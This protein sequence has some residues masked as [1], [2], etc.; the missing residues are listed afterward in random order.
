MSASYSAYASSCCNSWKE[1]FPLLSGG[2]LDMFHHAA[3]DN[4]DIESAA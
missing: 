3:H 1:D 4:I 2:D